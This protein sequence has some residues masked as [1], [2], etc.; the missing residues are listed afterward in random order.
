MSGIIFSKQIA[1]VEVIRFVVWGGLAL[2]VGGVVGFSYR[3]FMERLVPQRISSQ[4][5]SPSNTPVQPM[6]PANG[7]L[8][9]QSKDESL[10]VY[11]GME[12]VQELKIA[13]T[14]KLTMEPD[15]KISDNLAS[16]VSVDITHPTDIKNGVATVN[17]TAALPAV[18]NDTYMGTV[19]LLYEGKPTGVPLTVTLH[20]KRAD[21]Q[22]IPDGT[23][24]PSPGRIG[25]WNGSKVVE[26]TIVVS[27]QDSVANKSA[28]IRAVACKYHAQILGGVPDIGLF[29]LRIPGQRIETLLP[30][31]DKIGKEAGV[32]SAMADLL[33]EA[34]SSGKNSPQ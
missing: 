6:V 14:G 28:A 34:D 33:A 4:Q 23:D 15:I 26:D 32:R 11:E 5:L 13:M 30:I 19:Q 25:D 29:E 8:T 22:T 16:V 2:I 31:I 10:S 12:S 1:G 7:F 27:V 21:C 18:A 17:M 3:P 9:W 24:R 20:T